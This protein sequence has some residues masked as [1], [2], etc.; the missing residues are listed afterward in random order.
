MMKRKMEKIIIERA[1]DG[2]KQR[3]ESAP[4]AAADPGTD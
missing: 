3:V 2:L 4:G 1:L